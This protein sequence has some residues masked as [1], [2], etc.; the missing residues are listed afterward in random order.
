M[1][2]EV[3]WHSSGAFP[4]LD[5]VYHGPDDVHRWW[6]SAKEPFESWT[7]DIERHEE[8]GEKLV[9]LVTFHAVGKES[10]VTVDQPFGQLWEFEGSVIRRFWAYRTWDEAMAAAV[11]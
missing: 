8:V 5:P 4:G 2:P 10:G 1:H 6:R 7:I 11:G 3:E 9:V